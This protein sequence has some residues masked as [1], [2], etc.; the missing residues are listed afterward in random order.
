MQRNFPMAGQDEPI[1]EAG[2]AMGKAD[3][4]LVPS[5]N[6]AGALTWILTGPAL[7]RRKNRETRRTSTLEDA[8]TYVSGI[9]ALLEG[10]LVLGEDRQLS[11][12]VWVHSMDANTE[13][14]ISEGDAVVVGD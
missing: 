13:S 3:L 9:V 10:E 2:L 8:P 5:V 11:G 12:R 7:A 14:G 4:E 6:E 1:R